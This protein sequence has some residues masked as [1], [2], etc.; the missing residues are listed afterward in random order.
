MRAFISARYVG[1]SQAEWGSR[2]GFAYADAANFAEFKRLGFAAFGQSNVSVTLPAWFTRGPAQRVLLRPEQKQSL[3]TLYNYQESLA[4][5]LIQLDTTI[6]ALRDH[7][8]GVSSDDLNKQMKK[9]VGLAVDL[10]GF[11]E[12]TFF[13]LFDRLVAEGSGG[14]APRNSS[15]I[16]EITAAGK[17]KVTK[18]LTAVRAAG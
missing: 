17:Q 11:R 13:A 12:N 14:R 4:K 10:G 15:L 2:F 16:L 8:S 18:V 7:L 5:A 9:F 3:I 1:R 6:D